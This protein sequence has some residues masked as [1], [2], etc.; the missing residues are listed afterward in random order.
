MTIKEHLSILSHLYFPLLI[1]IHLTYENIPIKHA[2]IRS[3]TF[4]SKQFLLLFY[5]IIV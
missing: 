1:L 4:P 5:H 2:P 3:Q